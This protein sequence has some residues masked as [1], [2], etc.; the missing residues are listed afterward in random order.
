MGPAPLNVSA[1]LWPGPKGRPRPESDGLKSYA[2][3][4]VASRRAN[5]R[6]PARH[7][8]PPQG[9]QPQPPSGGSGRAA[10]RGAVPPPR[11]RRCFIRVRPL[12]GSTRS[13]APAARAGVSLRSTPGRC[14]PPGWFGK[15]ATQQMARKYP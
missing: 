11:C 7:A 8:G 3:P 1:A 4:G 2:P 10:H 6:P 9:S 14:P 12:R 13:A 15:G 5:S